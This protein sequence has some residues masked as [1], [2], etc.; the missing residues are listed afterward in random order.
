MPSKARSETFLP[1][2]GEQTAAEIGLID[3]RSRYLDTSLGRFLPVDS[4]QPA[5]PG[6]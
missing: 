6:T 4:V 5:A 3:L 1:A 2:T